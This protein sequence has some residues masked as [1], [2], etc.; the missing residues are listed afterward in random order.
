MVAFGTDFDVISGMQKCV[1]I[2]TEEGGLISH[3]SVVARELCKPC[4]IG[5]THAMNHLNDGDV[6]SMG[7]PP[8]TVQIERRAKESPLVLPGPSSAITDLSSPHA[9]VGQ[10]A[11]NLARVAKLGLAVIP[12]YE[13][14][15][16][17][18][19]KIGSLARAVIERVKSE[20]WSQT[21]IVRSNAEC[22]DGEDASFA[23]AFDT[24]VC[25][26]VEQSLAHNIL[27][28][29][30]SYE[31]VL[32]EKGASHTVLVQPMY[33]Q[34][35]GGVA[36]SHDPVS[37]R[38]KLTLEASRDGAARI[39]KGLSGQQAAI[40]D[41]MRRAI[42]KQVSVIE[43]EFGRPVNVEWGWGDEGLKIFQARPVVN[44]AKFAS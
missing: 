42:G 12:G 3:A 25:E 34:K 20:E 23:G 11:R 37:G 35:L 26:A 9:L 39:T 43:R 22:E 8:G 2:I 31:S 28:V 41:G 32:G 17:K 27:L 10:K 44:Y 4:I 21:I 1:G 13:I 36:F 40:E 14:R 16:I 18:K 5:A 38:R 24:R 15:V 33:R 6:I 30:Q 19:E 7:S 29:L